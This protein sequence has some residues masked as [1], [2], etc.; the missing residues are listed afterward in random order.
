MRVS[1]GAVWSL[2]VYYVMFRYVIQ[3]RAMRCHWNLRLYM[4]TSPV[5]ATLGC[6]ACT[7]PQI[8][9]NTNSSSS[10]V[11]VKSAS[12]LELFQCMKY[13]V[14]FFNWKWCVLTLDLINSL[15]SSI[16][17]LFTFVPLGG[18]MEM[19]QTS[20]CRLCFFGN[21][22]FVL[23]GTQCSNIA[24]WPCISMPVYCAQFALPSISDPFCF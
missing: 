8:I 21:L 14:F 20:K 1:A 24:D 5:N 16:N 22:F 10:T 19:W 13:F 7:T 15:I 4:H 11:A 6:W 23:F 17:L 18:G 3:L 9:R 12:M 2:S